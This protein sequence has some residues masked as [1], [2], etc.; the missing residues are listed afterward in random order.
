MF[1]Y[2]KAVF[3]WN[4]QYWLLLALPG[5]VT[6]LILFFLRRPGGRGLITL[7]VMPLFLSAS[8]TAP[9]EIDTAARAAIFAEDGRLGFRPKHL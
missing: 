8:G 7:L 6:F 1:R 9:R 2:P 4:N 3:H 5:L